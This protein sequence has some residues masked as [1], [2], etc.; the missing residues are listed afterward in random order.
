MRFDH[1][2]KNL[3][4]GIDHINKPVSKDDTVKFFPYMLVKD[5]LAFCVCGVVIS[6]V[7]F[8]GPNL[9]AEVD[10]YIPADPLVTPA[11][12]VPE[13][14]LL[15]FY[16]ILRAIPSKLGGVIFMFASIFVLAGLPW[17]DSSKV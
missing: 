15:P 10:N 16:A 8:F 7:I 1:I 5:T 9:M 2:V 6:L 14:Y 3:E 11:H 12:I 13:W 17:L 4:Y